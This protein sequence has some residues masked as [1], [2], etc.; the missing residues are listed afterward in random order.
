MVI[1]HSHF[2]K[3]FENKADPAHGRMNF[4]KTYLKWH[5]KQFTDHNK[6]VLWCPNKEC[7][8]VI[9]RSE[10]DLEDCV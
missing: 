9:V 6:N 4:V 3:Y 1:P 10:Y 8:N 5:L 2:L 7:D